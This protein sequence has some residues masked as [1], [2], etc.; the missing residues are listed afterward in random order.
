MLTLDIV[1][2]QFPGY[3]LNLLGPHD[4]R[5]CSGGWFRTTGEFLMAARC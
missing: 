5:H 2:K 1:Q 4:S 3:R